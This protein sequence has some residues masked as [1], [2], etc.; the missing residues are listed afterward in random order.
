MKNIQKGKGDGG[1]W[2]FPTSSSSVW[3][4]NSLIDFDN[5]FQYSDFSSFS[6][7]C[8]NP[9]FEKAFVFES[10]SVCL[11]CSIF[12]NHFFFGSN[13]EWKNATQNKIGS[14]N[15]TG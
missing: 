9:S 2:I 6:S 5:Q 14:T 10:L 1:E 4:F 3:V 8:D 12:C 7:G 11:N 15:D 13:I